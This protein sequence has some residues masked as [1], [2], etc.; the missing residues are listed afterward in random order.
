VV[1]YDGEGVTFQVPS[2]LPD[3]PDH[4]EALQF[5]GTIVPFG[6]IQDT[7]RVGYDMFATFLMLGQYGPEFIGAGIRLE[8]KLAREIRTG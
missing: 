3:S 1:S 6:V 8:R 5:R 4:R 7:A 2:H